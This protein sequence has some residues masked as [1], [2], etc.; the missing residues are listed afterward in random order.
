MK[1]HRISFMN[2]CLPRLRA[3]KPKSAF[4]HLPFS[5]LKQY[6]ICLV[7]IFALDILF[8]KKLYLLYILVFAPFVLLVFFFFFSR[9]HKQSWMRGAALEL[10]RS[11]AEQQVL[12]HTG[13]FLRHGR[14]PPGAG[15][16]LSQEMLM[17]SGHGQSNHDHPRTYEKQSSGAPAARSTANGAGE[18]ST[19]RQPGSGTAVGTATE[20]RAGRASSTYQLKG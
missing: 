12:A 6:C 11:T 1:K 5:S 3:R 4:I 10:A 14:D 7:T 20:G 13:I 8:E 19:A 16:H 17:R 18:R 2:L 9:I 15:K